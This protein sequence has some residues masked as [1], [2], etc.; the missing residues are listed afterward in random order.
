MHLIFGGFFTLVSLMVLVFFGFFAGFLTVAVA[1]DPEAPPAAFFWVL[2]LFFFMI[3]FVM[4]LPSLITGY[5]MLKRKPWAR[6]AGIVAGIVAGFSF[7][8]GTALCI[9]SLWYFFGDAGKAFEQG[10]AAAPW[11]GSLGQGRPSGDYPQTF[12]HERDPQPA[13]RPPA[14][15]PDWRNE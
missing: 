9:Y 11:H 7:P 15:P 13:Y 3:Y 8:F 5:A 12:G 10:L 6:I 2:A 4:S 14:Q 1:N